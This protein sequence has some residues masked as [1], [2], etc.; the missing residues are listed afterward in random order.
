MNDA[1]VDLFTGIVALIVAGLLVK[2]VVVAM[3][4]G[5]IPLYKTRMTREEAGEA[6]FKT[7]VALN[8]VGALAMFAIGS[9]LLLD[10]GLRD[11]L[12][13]R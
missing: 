9:D 10:L 1:A 13:G 8:M 7:L 12:T 5:I 11:A 3:R 2:R 6:K 4:D